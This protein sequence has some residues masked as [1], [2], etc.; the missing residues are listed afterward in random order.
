MVSCELALLRISEACNNLRPLQNNLGAFFHRN[1]G[2][3]RMALNLFNRVINF[4]RRLSQ[5]SQLENFSSD[6][7]ESLP[8]LAYPGLI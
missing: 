2:F 1:E 7:S 4:R 6:D 5:I 8:V 3:I